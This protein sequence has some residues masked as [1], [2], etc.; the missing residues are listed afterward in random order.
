MRI[1]VRFN[2]YMCVGS[3][4]SLPMVFEVSVVQNFG[5]MAFIVFFSFLVCNLGSMTCGTIAY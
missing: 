2:K 5:A 3:L 4:Q 1:I